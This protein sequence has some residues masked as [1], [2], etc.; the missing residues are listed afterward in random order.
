MK[1][2]WIVVISDLFLDALGQG[3]KRR[4]ILIVVV[5]VNHFLGRRRLLFY[6]AF[7]RLILS[8]ISIY[9]GFAS[10]III[11]FHFR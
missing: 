1:D 10:A 9:G 3:L 6:F 2:E 4:H 8:T 5:R 11:C 7:D